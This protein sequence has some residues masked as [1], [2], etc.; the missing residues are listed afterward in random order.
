MIHY[1]FILLIWWLLFEPARCGDM[2]K[3][4]EFDGLS[5]RLYTRL[6]YHYYFLHTYLC[7]LWS[8][9]S[10]TWLK[11]T[12]SSVSKFVYFL[13][14]A[15]PASYRPNTHLSQHVVVSFQKT[16]IGLGRSNLHISTFSKF[17]QFRELISKSNYMHLYFDKHNESLWLTTRKTSKIESYFHFI[18]RAGDSVNSMAAQ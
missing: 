12:I 11:V 8:T 9:A 10:S 17:N 3:Q 16:L 4:A 14:I 1:C 7:I 2:F 13:S 18:K 6:H 15:A 5:C